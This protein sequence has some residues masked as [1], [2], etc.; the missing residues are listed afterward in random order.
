M[1]NHEKTEIEFWKELYKSKEDYRAFRRGELA[2]K[3]KHFPSFKTQEGRGLDVGCGLISILEDSDKEFTAG[4]PLMDLYQEITNFKGILLDGE[5]LDFDDATFDWV[6]CVNVIDH[7]PNPK[8]MA[9]EIY[10]VLKPVGRLYF[11]VN[12]DDILGPAH[13]EL[14]NMDKVRDVMSK[15]T[16]S[17]SVLERNEP[18]LQSLYHAEYIK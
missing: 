4:D 8:K 9:D 10:R 3:T 15:F 14:W 1:N 17:T 16:L 6:L 13:Y 7:T 11:E 2:T 5:S 12:F 18:D